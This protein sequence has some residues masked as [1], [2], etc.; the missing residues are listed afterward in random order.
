VINKFGSV[1]L[2]LVAIFALAGC[3]KTNANFRVPS[4]KEAV[5]LVG[6]GDIAD[7]SDLSEAESTVK[8]LD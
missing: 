5:V 4:Q 8:F 6:A 1:L 3:A 7:C 2:G